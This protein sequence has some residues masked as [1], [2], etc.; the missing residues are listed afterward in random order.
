MALQQGVLN[1]VAW[2]CHEVTFCCMAL[3]QGALHGVNGFAVVL[4]GFATTGI[5]WCD[6]TTGI[7]LHGTV[8]TAGC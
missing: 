7:A 8:G 4:H 2:H 1:G 6:V 5:A 3:Q